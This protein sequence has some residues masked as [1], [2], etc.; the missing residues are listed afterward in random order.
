MEIVPGRMFKDVVHTRVPVRVLEVV[1]TDASQARRGLNDPIF[2]DRH[3]GAL[4]RI[5]EIHPHVTDDTLRDARWGIVGDPAL[6]PV[7]SDHQVFFLRPYLCGTH[8]FLFRALLSASSIHPSLSDCSHPRFMANRSLPCGTI[9]FLD[10]K[11]QVTVMVAI[12]RK[13]TMLLS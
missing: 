6:V 2:T 7:L 11:N 8:V 4:L 12:P 9:D 13:I 1:Y 5:E 3:R 10:A